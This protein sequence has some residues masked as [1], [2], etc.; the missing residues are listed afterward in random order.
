MAASLLIQLIRLGFELNVR[1]STLLVHPPQ[2]PDPILRKAITENK[3]ELL[4]LV[5]RFL[6]APCPEKGD[7]KFAT[8]ECPECDRVRPGDANCPRC[9]LKREYFARQKILKLDIDLAPGNL[10][11]QKAGP[12]TDPR[13]SNP[14]P[15]QESKTPSTAGNQE[16]L[17]QICPGCRSWVSFD[18][19]QLEP[20]VLFHHTCGARVR[21]G[22]DRGM[23][24]F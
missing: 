21:I 13:E 9:Q 5:P 17:S 16:S 12:I 15:V 20:G 10:R 8:F 3:A 18:R 22:L 2:R 1:G 4:K 23:Y 24:W 11:D 6:R 14:E 7:P 19:S